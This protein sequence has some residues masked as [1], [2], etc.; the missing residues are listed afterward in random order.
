VIGA[1]ARFRRTMTR[2]LAI[3]QRTGALVT[4]GV[5]PT[6]PE[7]GYGYIRPGAPLRG[8]AAGAAWVDAFVEKPPLARARR[9]LAAGA[10]WNSGMFVWR[11]DRILE[12]L[13]QLL[14]EVYEPLARAV[15]AGGAS[16]LARAYRRLPS[17]SIDTG[18]MERAE[19]VAV[20]PADF[21]WSD[22]GSWAAVGALWRGGAADGAAARGRVVAV[23]SRRC[24]VDSP[25]RLVALLGVDD[26]VVV[27]S[28]DAVLVCRVDRA[29]D[30]RRVVAELERR[31][32]GRYL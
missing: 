10:L 32:L 13:Q 1:G 12:E 11:V 6:C 2:A 22:V 3:A 7:T 21:P 26:L 27:D 14:P 17:V 18:V 30:V 16:A 24:V 4:L 9:L 25:E 19:R 31:G 5:R 20:V 23:D 29:Q 28:P 8:A 15:H